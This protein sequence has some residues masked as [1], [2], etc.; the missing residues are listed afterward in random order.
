M[1][2]LNGLGVSIINFFIGIFQ[3]F[4]NLFQT[5]MNDIFGNI[6]SNINYVAWTEEQNLQGLGMWSL[7]V[8][9]FGFFLVII[10]V[11]GIVKLLA[12]ESDF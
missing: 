4:G 5:G 1:S 12:M 8:I 9:M 11:I 3:F 10:V 6:V 7:F 2:S